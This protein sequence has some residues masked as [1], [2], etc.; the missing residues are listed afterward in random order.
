MLT[1]QSRDCLAPTPPAGWPS[2]VRSPPRSGTRRGPRGDRCWGL[3]G[4]P[5]RTQTH[6]PRTCPGR[7][8]G[9]RSVGGP[10]GAPIRRHVVE[11]QEGRVSIDPPLHPKLMLACSAFWVHFGYG[12]LG[13][14]APRVYPCASLISVDASQHG[15]GL[16]LP[17]I[18]VPKRFLI[19]RE[20]LALSG[21]GCGLRALDGS[22]GHWFLTGTDECRRGG[23]TRH[24]TPYA[25]EIVLAE[26]NP[27][28]NR[29]TTATSLS[30]RRE[31]RV[32]QAPVAGKRL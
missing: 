30:L 8:G 24:S 3:K 14:G 31:P 21:G 28:S 26:P 20:L 32:L 22:R 19:E 6:P 27:T 12:L 18:E 9:G 23:L 15:S 2:A 16:A 29:G 11:R 7:G 25:H 10:S 1:A 13:S 5:L 17:W 4:P